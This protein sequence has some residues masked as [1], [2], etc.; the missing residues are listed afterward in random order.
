MVTEVFNRRGESEIYESSENNR[1]NRYKKSED[2]EE[3][4]DSDIKIE[5]QSKPLFN[6]KKQFFE[7]IKD[8]S[9]TL[10]T[11]ESINHDWKN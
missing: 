1:F 3:L 2:S 8:E 6:A 4:N 7:K 5:S 10:D 9:L 11:C